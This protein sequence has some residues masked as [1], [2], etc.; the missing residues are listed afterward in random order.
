MLDV[1]ENARHTSS[2][3]LKYTQKIMGVYLQH[4]LHEF[5][6]KLSSCGKESPNCYHLAFGFVTFTRKFS[7]ISSKC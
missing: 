1:F 2:K 6:I 3:C 4:V 7:E 5:L